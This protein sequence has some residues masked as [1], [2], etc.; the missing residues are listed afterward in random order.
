MK[1]IL[2]TDMEAKSEL[3][4]KFANLQK[5][6]IQLTVDAKAVSHTSNE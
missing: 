2:T 1:L 3:D 5:L 4:Q 6:L